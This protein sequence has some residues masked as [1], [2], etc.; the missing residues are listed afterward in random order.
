MLPEG[1][2]PTHGLCSECKRKLADGFTIFVCAG[3][4]PLFG[5]H[6]ILKDDGVAGKIGMLHNQSI[7]EYPTMYAA[8]A[9]I[10]VASVLFIELLGWVEQRF[11][12][13]EKRGSR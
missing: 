11:L 10:I 13:P 4:I 2:L 5:K 3:K 12:R 6:P 7:A 9:A 8:I 1:S